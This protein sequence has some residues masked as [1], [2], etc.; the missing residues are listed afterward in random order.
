MDGSPLQVVLVPLSG[1][2][3]TYVRSTSAMVAP[4][5]AV[6]SVRGFLCVWLVYSWILGGA[7]WAAG[8]QIAKKF[9]FVSFLALA[10]CPISGPKT[11]RCSVGGGHRLMQIPPRWY[12]VW[13]SDASNRVLAHHTVPPTTYLAII[14][15]LHGTPYT[16]EHHHPDHLDLLEVSRRRGLFSEAKGRINPWNKAPS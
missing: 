16:S 5:S 12:F 9:S 3:T 6:Q 15:S 4:L 11:A 14:Y 1:T 10:H 8:K 7:A 13:F 2:P